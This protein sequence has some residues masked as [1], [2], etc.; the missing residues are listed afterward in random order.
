MTLEN[1][2]NHFEPSGRL[3]SKKWPISMILK[4]TALRHPFVVVNPI[5]GKTVM[6]EGAGE[7]KGLIQPDQLL[8]C[9]WL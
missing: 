6:K 4:P 2:E 7:T 3:R 8:W 1:Q 9:Q 5:T